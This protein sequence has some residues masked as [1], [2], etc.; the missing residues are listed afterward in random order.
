MWP[1]ESKPLAQPR[2]LAPTTMTAAVNGGGGEGGGEGEVE[3][4]P[5][6][7]ARRKSSRKHPPERVGWQRAPR[8]ADRSGVRSF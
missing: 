1:L 5:D 2:L 7:R 8:L 6:S 3:Y 4:D